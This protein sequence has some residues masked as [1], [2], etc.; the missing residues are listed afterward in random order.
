MNI[1]VLLRK[2]RRSGK[3]KLLEVFMKYI[4]EDMKYMLEHY[5]IKR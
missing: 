2:I 3:S 4:E 5:T 1:L